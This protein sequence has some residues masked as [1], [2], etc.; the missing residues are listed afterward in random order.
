[1]KSDDEND[2]FDWQSPRD[3]LLTIDPVTN[4]PAPAV[5]ILSAAPTPTTSAAAEHP[6]PDSP[7]KRKGKATAGRTFGRDTSSNREEEADQRPAKMRRRYHVITADSDEDD[8]RTEIPVP[9][10]MQNDQPGRVRK[11]QYFM[12]RSYTHDL[13]RQNTSPGPIKRNME[14]DYRQKE[15]GKIVKVKDLKPMCVKDY[16]EY[17]FSQRSPALLKDIVYDQAK[18]LIG[19]RHKPITLQDALP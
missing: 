11:Q 3:H 1:M 9:K 15:G 5:P 14:R 12:D 18:Q 16:L 19:L 17:K 4:T 7:A 13:S 10:P 8:S 6:T 2:I